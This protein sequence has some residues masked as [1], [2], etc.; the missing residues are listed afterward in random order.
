MRHLLAVMLLVAALLVI[1]SVSAMAAPN[2]VPG[3]VISVVGLQPFS[4]EANYMSLPGYL[5]WQGGMEM[6][7]LQAVYAVREQ[8]CDPTLSCRDAMTW[9]GCRPSQYPAPCPHH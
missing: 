7:Y 2:P 6:T 9:H 3:Q 4:P 8:G 5:R 1:A